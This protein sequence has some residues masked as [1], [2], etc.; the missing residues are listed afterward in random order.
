MKYT[1][2]KKQEIFADRG[3]YGNLKTYSTYPILH[4]VELE[5]PYPLVQGQKIVLG[6]EN[7]ID[8]NLAT[9]ELH[10]TDE[11]AQVEY[12]IPGTLKRID[13]DENGQ[14]I[15]QLKKVRDQMG[16]DYFLVKS[17]ELATILI[18]EGLSVRML[19]KDAPQDWIHGN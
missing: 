5:L 1:F 3:Y 19:P 2:I 9:S 8:F 7:T 13:F 10:R 18:K 15:A 4:V 12:L 6:P 16:T 11:G 17:E 14:L